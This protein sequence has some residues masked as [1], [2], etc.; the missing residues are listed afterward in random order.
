MRLWEYAGLKEE[1]IAF[2]VLRIPWFSAWLTRSEFLD[3]VDASFEKCPGALNP[4]QSQG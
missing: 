1:Y 2:N 4:K 3:D